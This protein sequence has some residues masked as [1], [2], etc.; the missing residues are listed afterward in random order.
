MDWTQQVDN[1]C[2]RLGPGFYGE[3]INAITNIAFFIAAFIAYQKV[4][5]DR[6]AEF[7]CFAIALIGLGSTLFHTFATQWAALADSLSILLFLLV[8]IHISTRRVLGKDKAIALL[9][10]LLFLPYAI[11]M[12]RVLGSIVGSLNGS[13]QY[14]PVVVL[15]F[16][17][18]FLAKNTDTRRGFWIGTLVLSI[19]IAF[20][21][22]DQMVCSYLPFGT[23]FLWHFLNAAV[24]A[25]MVVVVHRAQSDQ[26]TSGVELR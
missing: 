14:V 4:R 8:Y 11:I 9:T 12:E 2:E 13:L 20:R 18:G 17:Y 3:P 25:W 21:T 16:I 15:M 22:V 24:L 1:Y 7:L 19:S 10:V 6:G 26:N 5:G 23:H